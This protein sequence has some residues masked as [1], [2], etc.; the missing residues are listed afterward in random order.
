MALLNTR[1]MGLELKSPLIV[2][3]G[4]LTKDMEGLKKC[5]EAG[6][7]AVVLKSIFE[8]QILAETGR[9][10]EGAEDYLIHADSSLQFSQMAKDY[11]IERYC[12]LIGDAKKSLGIPVIASINCKGLSSWI[13]YCERFV[14]AGADAL[15]LNFFPIESDISVK[16]SAVEEELFKLVEVARRRI[17]IPLSIKL[18]KNYSS[19]ANVISRVSE[20]GADAVVLFNRA[21]RPDIDIEKLEFRSA[22]VF[23]GEQE[24]SDA[25][26]WTALM[27]GDIKADIA[28]NTGVHS[29]DS[30]VKMILAGASAVEI[31][32]VLLE[33]G[34]EAIG[35]MNRGISDYMDRHGFEN[36]DSFKARLSQERLKEGNIWERVQFLKTI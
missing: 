24:Y 5:A 19:L 29:S 30:A 33:K 20:L 25:L 17:G 7:G 32:S 2:A 31:C 26:R 14:A 11:Y 4:P 13:D 15:E 21:F 18:S 22:G 27:S 34:V 9:M 35:D 6:A 8:E 36:I 12:N 28:A 3:S 23:S 1:Y 10:L 16:G